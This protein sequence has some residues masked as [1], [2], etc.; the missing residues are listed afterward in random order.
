[1]NTSNNLFPNFKYLS[2]TKSLVFVVVFHTL[3]AFQCNKPHEGECT[4]VEIAPIAMAIVPDTG[5]ANTNI[6]IPIQYNISN[7]CGNFLTME[8]DAQGNNRNILVRARYQ[9]CVCTMVFMTL[10]TVYNFN[11]SAPGT[12]YLNFQQSDN[13]FLRDSIT[14]Q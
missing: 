4:Y 7:G 13:N 9:G 14:I 12:Y 5:L 10:D 6:P 8:E 3:F 1:M 2:V 11:A